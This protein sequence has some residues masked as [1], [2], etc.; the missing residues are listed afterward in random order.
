MK[1]RIE[2]M[3]RHAARSGYHGIVLAAYL[4]IGVAVYWRVLGAFFLS[5]DFEF[6]TIVVSARSWLVIFEPLVGRFVR[7][8]VVL[9]YY[10][11][12]KLFGLTPAPYHLVVLALHVF[13]AWWV[14]LIARRL[15]PG[16]DRAGAV[17]T[18]L[19]FLVFS[20]HSE[21][22]AW[23]A[24]VADLLLA[25]CLLPAFLAYLRALE[26]AASAR[27]LWVSFGLMLCGILAKEAWVVFPPIVF[28]HAVI[29]AEQ[30]GHARRRAAMLIAASA[31]T[32]IGY[33]LARRIIFGAV[34]AGYAGLGSSLGSEIFLD[35]TRTFLLR[36]IVP[37]GL[38][39]LDVFQ[40]RLD[41]LIWPLLAVV[42]IAR[43]RGRSRRV[44]LFVA[45]ATVI[46]LAPVLPLTISI[47]STESERFTY[48]P[49][50]FSSLFVVAAATTVLRWRPLVALACAPLILWHAVV[51]TR[52]TTRLRDAGVMARGII[53]SFAGTVRRHDAANREPIFILNLPD[54]LNGAYIFRRGFYPAIQLFAPD[55]ADRTARTIGIATNTFVSPRDR[56]TV[57]QAAENRFVL[58]L[59]GA[60]I[61]QPQIP[62]SVWYTIVAQGPASYH[63]QFAETNGTAVVLF[64]NGMRVE[65][66]GTIASR[67][68]PFG[69]VEIPAEGSTCQGEATRFSGWAFDDRGV[70][71]VFVETVAEDGAPVPIGRATSASGTRSDVAATFGWLP[72]AG[73]V[74]WNYRLACATVAAARDG[75][76]RVRVTT[77]DTDGQHAPLGS[78]VVRAVR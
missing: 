55:V 67:G 31:L 71:S 78:R 3:W 8:L 48:L 47:V 46:A 13:N 16:G 68:I 57:R 4:A 70:S 34:T 56:V 62:S 11:C 45:C 40:R 32:V 27:W 28:A 5:D 76:L 36:S 19:L 12:Y 43:G 42:L 38:R 30:T 21:A 58:D 50:A 23:T 60:L 64:T 54:S 14:Y 51:L 66:A 15:L 25:A 73:R 37:G 77:V 7:P 59:G 69:T 63:V 18:G 44:V 33:L 72:A 49:T 61:V 41:L 52:N 29:L 6:L 74:E 22:V 75:A 20:S 17:L 65:H 1:S 9:V 10:V 35:Q 53:D 24:G 39:A 2:A 26:P